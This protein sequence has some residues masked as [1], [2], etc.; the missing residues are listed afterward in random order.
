MV[1]AYVSL[2]VMDRVKRKSVFEH[3]QNAQIQ[4][5]PV[6]VQSHLGIWSPSRGNSNEYPQHILL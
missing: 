3:V 5:Q 2:N 6:H 1:F 4:I